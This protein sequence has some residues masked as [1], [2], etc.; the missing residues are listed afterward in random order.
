MPRSELGFAMYL[1]CSMERNDGQIYVKKFVNSEIPRASK[2]C[3]LS[4]TCLRV[5]YASFSDADSH[6]NSVS[7]PWQDILAKFPYTIL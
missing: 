4:M 5:S 6:V 2:P 1:S 7:G 3:N